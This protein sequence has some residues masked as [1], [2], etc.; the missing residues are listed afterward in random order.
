MLARAR[1]GTQIACPSW[2]ALQRGL[3]L[4]LYHLLINRNTGNGEDQH[5][6]RSAQHF[7][8]RAKLVYLGHDL[9]LF[10]GHVGF[11]V[12]QKELVVLL[13]GQGTAI[14]QESD[15]GCCEHAPYDEKLE[16]SRHCPPR[17]RRAFLLPSGLWTALGGC[18]G[19]L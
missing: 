12:T 19:K 13:H 11:G 2:R 4:H 6:R 5:C 14:D 17:D 1:V 8:E 16:Q 7:Y 9:Y 15:K 18:V 10:L 3:L